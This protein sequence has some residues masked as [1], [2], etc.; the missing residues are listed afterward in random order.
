MNE[1]EEEEEMAEESRDWI[2]RHWQILMTIAIVIIWGIRLESSS[3]SNTEKN[4]R[5]Y[6]QFDEFKKTYREDSKELA[7]ALTDVSTSVTKLNETI[8]HFDDRYLLRREVDQR[9]VK[10]A[11]RDDK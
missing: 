10:T 5:L 9:L 3:T 7:T 8:K 1:D 6:L 4:Y 11:F 2:S